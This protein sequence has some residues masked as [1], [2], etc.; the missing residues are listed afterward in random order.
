MGIQ[1]IVVTKAQRLLLLITSYPV[2]AM[3][4][5]CI[6]KQEDFVMFLIITIFVL[7]ALVCVSDSLFQS[8]LLELIGELLTTIL[9]PYN[10]LQGEDS[11]SHNIVFFNRNIF[12]WQFFRRQSTYRKGTLRGYEFPTDAL[13][14]Y[15]Y[16]LTQKYRPQ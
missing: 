5:Y 3:L 12:L 2:L 16:I 13:C 9:I 8:L 6:I 11:L 7:T 14:L 10:I 15:A 1:K 4:N